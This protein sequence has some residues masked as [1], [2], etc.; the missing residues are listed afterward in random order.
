[1]DLLSNL[2][3]AVDNMANLKGVKM[4]AVDLSEAC[5]EWQVLLMCFSS[6]QLARSTSEVSI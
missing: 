3:M 6:K 5:L 4:I 1:M 2:W